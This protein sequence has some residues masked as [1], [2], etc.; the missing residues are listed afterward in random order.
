MA[1][2]YTPKLGQLATETDM[3]DAIHIALA[4][5]VAGVDL[6]PGQHVSLSQ[7]REALPTGVTIGIVDPFL[8]E[9]V[10]HGQRFWLFLYQNTVTGLRHSWSHPSF[11]VSG[12]FPPE[13]TKS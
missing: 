7:E 12:V 10:L 1:E 3:R 8:K 6:E 2:Q 13:I 4:P 5:V 9:R 11:K